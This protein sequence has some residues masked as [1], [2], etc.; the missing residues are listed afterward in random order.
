M[1][2][3]K[4][5]KERKKQGKK[6]RTETQFHEGRK[7]G[8]ESKKERMKEEKKER[9]KEKKKEGKVKEIGP[10]SLCVKASHWLRFN[11]PDHCTMVQNRTKHRINSHP[12]IHCFM[13][14]GV[15]KVSE[16]ANE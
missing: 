5:K 12:I 2:E 16:R 15:S 8:K 1:N 6:E 14:K 9:K 3:D 11:A 4:R 10:M 13:S 7:E